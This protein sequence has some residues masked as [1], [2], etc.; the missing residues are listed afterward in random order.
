MGLSGSELMSK[1]RSQIY[2]YWAR[3]S[4]N[5]KKDVQPVQVSSVTD[6]KKYLQQSGTVGYIDSRYIEPGMN[7]LLR[8]PDEKS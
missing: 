6:L 5:A 2:A 7:V 1:E 4:V 8:I 3:A